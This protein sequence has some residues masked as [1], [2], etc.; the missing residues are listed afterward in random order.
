MTREVNRLCNAIF[1]N[2][3]CGERLDLES[4]EMAV[5]QSVHRVG[6]VA[7][8]QIVNADNGGDKRAKIACGAGHHARFVNCR[9]KTV[10]TVLGKISVERAYYHCPA[11]QSGFI[12][13]DDLLDIAETQFSPGVR[14]MMA[15]VGAKESFDAG[16]C[17]LRILAGVNVTDKD[18]ERVAEAIGDHIEVATEKERRGSTLSNVVPL[19]PAIENL[20]IAMDGTGVPM[21]TKETEGRK[22][23]DE[24]GVAKTREAKLGV[25]FTTSGMDKEGHP[26]RD[27]DS[28][29]YTGGIE[30]SEEFGERIYAEAMRYGL[31]R[32]KRVSV[33]GDGAVWIWNI[34]GEKFPNAIQI[35]DYFHASEHLSD[36]AKV[37]HAKDKVIR[38]LWLDTQR[39]ELWDG[40]VALVI[41]SMRRME[42]DNKDTKEILRKTIQYFETNEQRMQY[43]KFRK[44]GL[45]V[46]SGVIEAGCK[47]IVGQ[48]L[49]Q[50]GMR[51]TV[52][53]ANAI[54]SLRCCQI[55][56]QW[57]DYWENRATA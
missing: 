46:G 23:K 16:S 13:K 14:R 26:I 4:V 33:L 48:R 19:L 17:D 39:T 56:G 21:V 36:L 24:S 8:E 2:Q 27:K 6:A 29:V 20:T 42:T 22:G 37:I 30:T 11:C 47:T 9:A 45:F 51:W 1:P 55:S 40:D 35:V 34:A 57:E 18:V 38:D 49:K 31:S 53:G 25:I 10:V 52:R 44:M 32:A 15:L 54:I 43:A 3:D 5:R 41:E 28:T 50:S 7:L 12:P